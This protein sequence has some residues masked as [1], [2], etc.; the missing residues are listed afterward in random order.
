MTNR[1][2][3]YARV[4]TAR[5]EQDHT[6]AS[7]IE[8]LERAASAMGFDVAADRRYID[9]GFSGSR[10]DRPGLDALRD[11]AAEG[12]LDRVLVYCP[13]RLARNYVHQHVLIEELNRRGVEVHFVERPIGER[14]EDRLLVQMQGV[15]AEYERAKITER[16]RRGKMHKLRAGQILPYAT[17]APYGYAITRMD[18]GSRM[19]VVDE[20]EAQNVRTMFRWVLDE[21][22]SARGVA[23][24][25]NEN[26]VKPRRAK[27]WIQGTVYKILTN[28]AYTGLAVC[29]GRESVEPRRPKKPGTYRRNPKSSSRPRPEAQWIRIPVPA[30]IDDADLREVRVQLAKNKLTAMRNTRR[31]YLLRTLI[32][33]GECGWRMECAHQKRKDGP[34]HYF[35]Y[36]C[37]H[38]DRL[39]GGPEQRC[40]AKRVR[41]DELDAVVWDAITTWIQSPQMLKQEVEGGRASRIGVEQ[42]ARDGS[43]LEAAERKLGQQVDRLVDAYQGGALSVD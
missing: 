14:A 39:E 26:G 6:V 35:Y 5:Q 8:G 28:P 37:R 23:K 9:D 25:L 4:S 38:A 1:I 10:L 22:L 18:A 17:E 13:Y 31:E 7:Q 3:I 2:A 19:V 16:T 30:L 40:T 41:R 29:Q 21:G 32:V 24:R 43:R 36:N 34:Y 33:C 12:L 15:I 42:A 11:A 27:G 20:V